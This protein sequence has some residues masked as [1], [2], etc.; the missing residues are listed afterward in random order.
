MHFLY[1]SDPLR[2]KRPDE[3]YAAEYAA[4]CA[5]GFKA[6]VFSLEEFQEGTFRPFPA[7]PADTVIYRG[8]M[9][10]GAEYQDLAAELSRFG[11]IPLTNATAYLAAHHLPN[12]YETIAEFTPET[13]IFPVT[14]DLPVELEKLKE[15]LI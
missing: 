10:S 14:A 13:R 7:L 2:T 11:A 5:A 6:S 1:P 3:Y 12:W 4:I 8:W 9:L 15:P